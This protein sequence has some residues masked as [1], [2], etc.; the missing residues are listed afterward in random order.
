M[1]LKRV[2]YKSCLLSIVL[3][4]TNACFVEN[5]FGAD[6]NHNKYQKWD[7]K[8][9]QAFIYDNN[10]LKYS[11]NYINLFVS[12]LNPG[13]FNINTYDDFVLNSSLRA[14]YTVNLIKNLKTTINVNANYKTYTHNNIKNW[15]QVSLGLKQHITKKSSIKFQYNYIPDYYIKHFR[16]ND[17]VNIYGYQPFTFKPFSFTKNSYELKYQNTLFNNTKLFLTFSVIQLFYNENFTEYDCNN[18]SYSIRIN[19]PIN[20]TV[21]VETGYR[22]INSNAKGYVQP[23][24]DKNSS[25]Y[26]DASN[27]DNTFYLGLG[28]KLPR[29]LKLKSSLKIKASFGKRLYK[30]EKSIVIDPLHVGRNDNNYRINF[31]YKIRPTKNLSVYGFYTFYKRNTGSDYNI[32]KKYISNE[33]DY[34]QYQTG[35]GI[36]YNFSL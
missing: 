24:G 25:P 30:S 14:S 36:T 19:Q 27:N 18:L 28:M 17:W 5:A 35:L 11:D 23:D 7:F 12:E 2:L 10:I 29:V 34:T 20:K 31:L 21:T 26:A 16:D 6:K 1:A 33:K 22:F 15:G 13:R 32:N 3:A 8:V 4:I 9:S